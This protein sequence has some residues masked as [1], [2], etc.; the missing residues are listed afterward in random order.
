MLRFELDY[1][2]DNRSASAAFEAWLSGRSPFKY[3]Q[4]L[5]QP[6]WALPT[7][8]KVVVGGLFY[9]AMTVAMARALGAGATGAIAAV[10]IVLVFITDGFW[11][12]LLFRRRR[13]DRA[14]VYLFPY[15]ILV[16]NAF[17]AMLATDRTSAVLVF[18]T[19]SSCLTTSLGQG[20]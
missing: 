2:H 11:N 6:W 9:L 7:W 19:C 13:L 4:S 5:R 15:S 12:Y 18:C 20:L 8:G 16:A 1:S 17:V 3:L 10:L 14:Y